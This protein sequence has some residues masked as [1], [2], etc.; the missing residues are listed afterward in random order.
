MSSANAHLPKT[1]VTFCADDGVGAAVP[2]VRRLLTESGDRV[3]VLLG[4]HAGNSQ[5]AIDELLSLKDRNLARLSLAFVTDREDETEIFSG[6]LDRPKIETLAGKLF[7]ARTVHEYF[8]CG[9]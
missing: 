9:P 1:V 5:D 2:L 7:D 8:V 4:H 3:W 6:R